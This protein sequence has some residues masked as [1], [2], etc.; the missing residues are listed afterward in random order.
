MTSCGSKNDF[1]KKKSGACLITAKVQTYPSSSKIDRSLHRIQKYTSE[2]FHNETRADMCIPGGLLFMWGVV[3]SF[4]FRVSIAASHKK[5]DFSISKM[6]KTLFVGR[7]K[8]RLPW[9]SSPS[10]GP[11]A[12]SI[13]PC[14]D[15]LC[16]DQSRT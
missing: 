7:N 16:H 15:K 3:S 4:R 1:Y 9:H 12:C 13:W 5:P 11:H 6:E 14:F 2:G 10:K 8:N